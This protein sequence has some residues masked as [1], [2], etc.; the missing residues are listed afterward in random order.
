MDHIAHLRNISWLLSPFEKESFK[1]GVIK[2][3]SWILLTQ[4]RRVPSLVEICPDV[5]DENEV[6]NVENQTRTTYDQKSWLDLFSGGSRNFKTRR[7]R[8]LVVRFALM[9]F[10]THPLFFVVG[11]ENKILIVL[12]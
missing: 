11:V 5:E 9:P 10:Y 4:R 8:N 1:Q 7:G 3:K 6:E 12:H 2:T